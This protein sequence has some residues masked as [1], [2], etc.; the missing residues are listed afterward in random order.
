[1]IDLHCVLYVMLISQSAH[2]LITCVPSLP[3]TVFLLLVYLRFSRVCGAAY[4]PIAL[5]RDF[6]V[7]RE[8]GGVKGAHVE[9]CLFIQSLQSRI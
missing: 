4:D 6:V 1:M 3:H 9:Q 7:D 8:T 5:C 2:V